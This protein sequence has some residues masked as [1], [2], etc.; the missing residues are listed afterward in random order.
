MPRLGGGDEWSKYLPDGQLLRLAAG[1]GSTR[2]GNLYA[3]GNFCDEFL[4]SE[5]SFR[6]DAGLSQVRVELGG[7]LEMDAG[8]AQPAGGFDVGE[9]VVYVDGLFGA[10]FAGSEGLAIDER[11]GLTGTNGARVGADRLWKI[12]EEI[13][14]GLEFFDVDGIRVRQQAETIAL[15]E[16][17]EEGSFVDR[18]GIEGGIPDPFELFEIERKVEALAEV[19]VPI[20]RGHAAFLPVWPAGVVFDGGPQFFGSKGKSLGQGGFHALDIHTD[21]DSANVKDYGAQFGHGYG[22]SGVMTGEEEGS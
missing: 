16:A 13:V 22:F 2:S 1:A 15:C 21:E 17:R 9:D 6:F 7:G 5:T 12:G 4:L 20:A 8:E 3:S 11:V 14:A 10:D 19:Q 18:V